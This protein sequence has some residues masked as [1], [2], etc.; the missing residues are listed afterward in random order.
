[1]D[2]V[3]D[4]QSFVVIKD[5][6]PWGDENISKQTSMVWRLWKGRPVAI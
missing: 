2:M 1:M 3:P 5:K 4:V 6:R